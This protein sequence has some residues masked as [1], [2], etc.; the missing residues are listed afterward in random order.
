[1]V[2][3]IEC[4][5]PLT[6][7]PI[8]ANREPSPWRGAIPP[9]T[10]DIRHPT[11]KD[12]SPD[13]GVF[14]NHHRSPFENE[15]GR[16]RYSEKRMT[17]TTFSTTGPFADAR[18]PREHDHHLDQSNSNL[19][20]PI[21]RSGMSGHAGRR[22]RMGISR[23]PT[24]HQPAWLLGRVT[25]PPDR[26]FTAPFCHA[27]FRGR[28]GCS[29]RPEFLRALELAWPFDPKDE[30]TRVIEI[31]LRKDRPNQRPETV[32]PDPIGPRPGEIAILIYPELR[33]Q[34][35]LGLRRLCRVAF[36][37]TPS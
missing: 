25:N 33:H 30:P 31:S 15:T 22:I 26:G 35:E 34:V 4:G 21:H 9:A 3:G 10:T 20:K 24:R 12:R 27:A 13:W 8:P 6:A 11:S 29:Q 7:Q 36:S 28:T 23:G 2:P 37:S 32:Q 19:V 1:M 14:P 18:H 16:G 17:K 5:R